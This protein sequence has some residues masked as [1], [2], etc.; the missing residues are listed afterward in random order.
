MKYAKFSSLDDALAYR[1][2]HGG[3]IFLTEYSEAYWFCLD[4]TPSRTFTSRM[5]KGLSGRL[6]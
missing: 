1:K 2:N 6:I 3:W 5:T 4:F